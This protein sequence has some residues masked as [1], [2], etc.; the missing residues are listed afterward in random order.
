MLGFLQGGALWLLDIGHVARP[1]PGRKEDHINPQII[2]GLG[3][4]GWKRLCRPRRKYLAAPPPPL[5]LLPAHPFNSIT[6][7]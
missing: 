5:D 1:V 3:K 6:R 4:A 7:A 2:A